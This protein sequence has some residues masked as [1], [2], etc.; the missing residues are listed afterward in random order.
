MRR[1]AERQRLDERD[2]QRKAR[3]GV[4]GQPRL[5]RRIDQR[6]EIGQAPQHLGGNRMR[7]RAVVAPLDPRGRTANRGLERQALAQ[8][9]IEQPQRGAARGDA[10][11]LDRFGPGHVAA[12]R[13]QGHRRFVILGVSGA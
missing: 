1:R 8:H 10:G 2:A 6:V 7:Q 9:G 11:W 5:G 3:L 12:G 13:G 4:I